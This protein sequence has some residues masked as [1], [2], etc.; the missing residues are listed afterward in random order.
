MV[1][2]FRFSVVFRQRRARLV[3][4]EIGFEYIQ[5]KALWLQSATEKML[6]VQ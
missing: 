6:Q 1:V 5:K 4:N 3:P 2:T